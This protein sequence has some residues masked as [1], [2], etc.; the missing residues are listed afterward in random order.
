MILQVLTKRVVI[1]FTEQNKKTD[2][3]NHFTMSIFQEKGDS[4]DSELEK[5]GENTHQSTA[6]FSKVWLPQ[7]TK[8]RNNKSE[9]G[10]HPR[11]FSTVWSPTKSKTL[12]S[13]ASRE[14]NLDPLITFSDLVVTH[15]SKKK[16]KS[17]EEYKDMDEKQEKQE[18]QETP[19]NTNWKMAIVDTDVD[20]YILTRKS[21]ETCFENKK[22]LHIL[23]MLSNVTKETAFDIIGNGGSEG[24]PFKVKCVCN[25]KNT[26]SEHFNGLSSAV[27]L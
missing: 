8:Q 1:F 3:Q 12:K 11:A 19:N 20:V 24:K 4:S 18:T 23:K 27:T 16:R 9:N 5:N 2:L 13:K 26:N 10:T 7:D 6:P 25:K 14:Q 22:G 15:K 21:C 17:R